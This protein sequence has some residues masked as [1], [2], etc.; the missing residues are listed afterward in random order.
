M[1]VTWHSDSKVRKEDRNSSNWV[2][3]YYSL[4]WLVAKKSAS[5][6][7]S[8]ALEIVDSIKS[9]KEVGFIRCYSR[10]PKAGE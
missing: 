3:Y 6:T 4:P 7:Y 8:Q 5:V 10:K 1:K 2:V 9:T